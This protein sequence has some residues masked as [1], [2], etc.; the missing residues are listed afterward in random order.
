M[1]SEQTFA[2]D[3]HGLVRVRLTAECGARR[4]RMLDAKLTALTAEIDRADI[5][6]RIG[7]FAPTSRPGPA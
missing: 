5:E 2:Y 1:P 3:L 4:G 7:S 6:M